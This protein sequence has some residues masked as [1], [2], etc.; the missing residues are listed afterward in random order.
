MDKPLDK[1]GTLRDDVR[2]VSPRECLELVSQG[3]LI[4]D[5]RGKNF[6]DFKIPDI[7]DIFLMPHRLLS[8]EYHKLPADRVLILADS[9]GLKSKEAVR[10]LQDKGFTQVAHMAGGFV[11]WERDG[12]PVREDINERL[13]GACACQLKPRDRMK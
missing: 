2:T 10:F 13:T 7:P 4:V 6:T 8:E 9:T 12:L 5:L 11:E 3:G 1:Y